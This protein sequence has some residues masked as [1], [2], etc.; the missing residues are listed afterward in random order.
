MEQ[1]PPVRK[2]ARVGARS[3]LGDARSQQSLTDASL[4]ARGWWLRAL[5]C[6]AEHDVECVV[7]VGGG[8]GASAGAGAG[9]SGSI[10]FVASPASCVAAVLSDAQHRIACLGG[11]EGMPRSLGS[12]YG[13]MVTQFLNGCF[14]G[15]RA[16]LLKT[17][18]RFNNAYTC[19]FNNAYTCVTPTYDGAGFLATSTHKANLYLLDAAGRKL[20]ALGRGNGHR[21]LF[22]SLPA[23]VCV[24]P[25]GFVFVAEAGNDRV[26]VLT[27][28]Y[29]FHAFLA[30]DA[31]SALRPR[32]VVATD[33]T[34][35]V[36]VTA[37]SSAAAHGDC[38]L[39]FERATGALLRKLGEGC[40][41]YPWGMC[42]LPKSG[43]LAVAQLTQHRVAFLNPD[44]GALER[45]IR[46][47]CETSFVQSTAHD[48]L[49]VTSCPYM[50]RGA[51]FVLTA[52]LE[53]HRVCQYEVDDDLRAAVLQ[54][55]TGEVLAFTAHAVEVLA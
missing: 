28:Q 17:H 45:E 51:I 5:V 31:F 39:V 49:V 21:P 35:F 25:D 18:A 52:E 6:V 29:K 1:S 9:D 3:R 8:L 54:P 38:V 27:P 4:N 10:A 41:I 11:R 37:V 26:Q 32:G 30:I 44:T 50:R 48:E 19:V 53:T 42:L 12:A 16:R 47:A 20:R 23:Q 2:R 15:E 7:N 22:F 24:A 34:V 33:T 46:F 40:L 14:R 13:G 55:R 36:S 43:L